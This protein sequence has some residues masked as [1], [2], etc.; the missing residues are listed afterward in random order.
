[1]QR[2]PVVTG[3]R[4]GVTVAAEDEMPARVR[5]GRHRLGEV[6]ESGIALVAEPDAGEGP[7]ELDDTFLAGGDPESE[8]LSPTLFDDFV[9]LL[10]DRWNR[11]NVD[12][13]GMRA[14]AEAVRCEPRLLARMMELAMRDEALDIA[15]VERREGLPP[16]DLRAAGT[17]HLVI[18]FT[19]PSAMEFFRADNTDPLETILRR[20]IAAARTVLI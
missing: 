7:H 16:G 9:Q 6:G 20:R 14:M 19:R 17:V 3:Q 12:T 4:K 13:D 5:P 18:A 2:L 11:S 10:V 1:M 8:T 15:L